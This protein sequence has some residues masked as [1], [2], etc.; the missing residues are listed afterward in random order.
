M[1]FSCFQPRAF[2]GTHERR[3]RDFKGRGKEE[4]NGIRVL[5]KQDGN[6][7][8]G[9]RESARGGTGKGVTVEQM[10]VEDNDTPG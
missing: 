10:N 6:Y 3:S 1:C 4:G 7:L 8:Q 5:R 9:E 2:R